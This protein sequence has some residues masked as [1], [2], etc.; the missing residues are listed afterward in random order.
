MP[1][2]PSAI[3]KDGPL[4]DLYSQSTERRFQS[5]VALP[6]PDETELA[7]LPVRALKSLETRILD[8]WIQA[9]E[10]IPPSLSGKIYLNRIKG[11]PSPANLEELTSSSVAHCAVYFLALTRLLIEKCGPEKANAWITQELQGVMEEG[12][13]NASN[14]SDAAAASLA[15]F[16]TVYS[17]LAARRLL[18]GSPPPPEIALHEA[19]AHRGM[20]QLYVT[21]SKARQPPGEN[22]QLAMLFGLADSAMGFL[23]LLYGELNTLGKRLWRERL[24]EPQ[25]PYSAMQPAELPRLARRDSSMISKY[26]QKQV[27]EVFEEQLSLAMQSFGFVVARTSRGKRRVDLVCI[28]RGHSE[29]ST[30]LI[31]AKTSKD[32]YTLPVAD[33]RALSE[34]AEQ[35]RS[36]LPT[37]PPLRL[38]LVIGQ[39]PAPSLE[40]RLKALESTT[41]IPMRFCSTD[42][43]SHLRISL[44]GPLDGSSFITQVLE[45]PVILPESLVDLIVKSEDD[46]AQTH[47]DYINK[48]LLGRLPDDRP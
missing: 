36:R 42:L 2:R 48:L 23:D 21:Q 27:E 20:R 14:S 13:S 25:G 19:G 43:L 18:A 33:Q 15:F 39:S 34:Y 47:A 26:G 41:G 46:E 40:S 16:G 32:P 28:S 11:D 12:A 22:W 30:F 24:H 17:T 9:I 10:E 5:L 38:V 3:S 35:T 29:A 44:V 37:L 8:L 1:R 7:E 4:S 6:V 45:S 31:E